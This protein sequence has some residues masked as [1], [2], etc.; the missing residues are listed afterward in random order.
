MNRT[1]MPNLFS[2]WGSVIDTKDGARAALRW[3]TDPA[4]GL[5]ANHFKVWHLPKSSSA[6]KQVD[7]SSR[8]IRGG[9]TLHTWPGQRA[10]ATV[11]VL[12]DIPSGQVRVRAHSGPS[13]AGQAVDEE[14]A[15]GPATGAVVTL[16]GAS[17]RS[18]TTTGSATVAAMAVLDLQQH[19]DDPNWKLL[20]HVGL[21][22]DKRFAGEY[23]LD[24]QGPVGAMT[25][26]VKAAVIRVGRGTPAGFWPG[27]TDTGEAAP[28]FEPPDPD[29]L[30]RGELE[31]VMEQL[32]EMLAETGDRSR[33]AGL[34]VERALNVPQSVHGT[35]A[36]ER[37]RAGSKAKLPPLRAA[38][39]A[40]GTDPYG[41]LALGFGTSIDGSKLMTVPWALTHGLAQTASTS[42]L[43]MVT[44]EHKAEFAVKV[45]DREIS[46]PFDHDL[47]ALVVIG[48]AGPAAPTVVR[49]N[50][51]RDTPRLDRPAGR[52]LPWLESVEVSWA[53]NR[54]AAASG[55]GPSTFAVLRSV[56]GSALEPALD[57]RPSGGHR[58]FVPGLAGDTDRAR[59]TSAAVPEQFPGESID[60]RFAVAAQDWFGRWSGWA[61]VD[62]KRVTVDPQRPAVRS[63]EVDEDGPSPEAVVEFTW[64]WSD[65]SP[66]AVHLRLKVFRFE[67]PDDAAPPVDGTVLIPGGPATADRIISFSGASPD[68][69]PTGVTEVIEERDGDLRT[70]RCRIPGIAL[71]YATHPRM[72]VEASARAAERVRPAT[73]GAFSKPVGVAVHSPLLP[74]APVTTAP[75]RWASLPDSAGICR[76]VLDWS[77]S[78]PTYTVYV[79][80]E[81][82]IARELGL[83]SPNLDM[84]AA[85]RLQALRGEDFHK[86]R[87]AFRRHAEQLVEPR[88]EIALPKGGKLIHFYGISAVSVTGQERPLPADADRYLAV[89]APVR[90][91]PAPP[92]LVARVEGSMVRLSASV[93]SAQVPVDRIAI[94][95]VDHRAKA[96][97]PEAA[98][99]PILTADAAT[100]TARDG[101]LHWELTDA[102]AL[103]TW[104]PV[105]YRAVATAAA[106][107]DLGQIAGRSQPGPAVEVVVPSANPPQVTGLSV[108]SAAGGT[109]VAFATDASRTRTRLGAFT[110]A[111]T[112]V[113]T[114]AGTAATTVLRGQVADLPIHT[115]LV[116]AGAPA[117]YLHRATAADPYRVTA[118]LDGTPASVSVE[119]T[120]PLGRRTSAT[121]STP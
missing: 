80:D 37:W 87:R 30:V 33:H 1:V 55:M 89:A 51:N 5:P 24:P 31:P 101:K 58:V 46:V 7:P 85:E 72:R 66:I 88:L 22:V 119:A 12:L 95:R 39:L 77:G 107:P 90:L 110:V 99:A 65:R 16:T 98:G 76:A 25:D 78:G 70:Y 57:K 81:T 97:T 104:T 27:A 11:R 35:D 100:A 19:V 15:I 20:E 68:S 69:P 105:F 114:A 28:P 44:L 14:I 116:P 74:P 94:G 21:P 4:L 52:D 61:S 121:W 120:D 23:P 102:T 86:A 103:P 67:H 115:G 84:P 75:M 118:R 73:L 6:P 32:A 10:A 41:A 108:T 53:A 92:L 111:V 45:G 63:V 3:M 106:D 47:A 43:L 82:A 112:A 13:G 29:A 36:P 8:R 9:L 117:L 40:A 93:A 60:A 71:P 79:A 26:P 2:A 54:P 64:D 91:E 109:T 42:L 50:E 59:F 38:L 48:G 56:G 113:H 96:V 17:I 18:V 83:A 49:T 34:V 62:H